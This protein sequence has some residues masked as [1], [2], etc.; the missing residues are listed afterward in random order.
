MTILGPGYSLEEIS[1][2]REALASGA[3]SARN[4]E[5]IEA[6]LSYM[7]RLLEASCG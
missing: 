3:L 4:S 5:V 7:A 6:A 1:E 2:A